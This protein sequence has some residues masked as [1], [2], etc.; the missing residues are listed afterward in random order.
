MVCP[1]LQ[2]ICVYIKSSPSAA[3]VTLLSPRPT[4]LRKFP[5]SFHREDPTTDFYLSYLL[6][7]Q[8]DVK[9]INFF[10][11]TNQAKLQREVNNGLAMAH[12]NATKRNLS[13]D[14]AE[15]QKYLDKMLELDH[16]H[17][18][19]LTYGSYQPINNIPFLTSS[20]SVVI[21]SV[22]VKVQ[23]LYQRGLD[24]KEG[25]VRFDTTLSSGQRLSQY[26]FFDLSCYKFS[27]KSEVRMKDL[28][29][30]LTAHGQHSLKA[31]LLLADRNCPVSYVCTAVWNTSHWTRDPEPDHLHKYPPGSNIKVDP[32]FMEKYKRIVSDIIGNHVPDYRQID[33]SSST[34]SVLPPPIPASSHSPAV[35]G[36]ATDELLVNRVGQVT[37]IVDCGNYGIAAIKMNSCDGSHRKERAIVLFDTCDV[38][39]GKVTVQQMDMNLNQVMIKGDYVK[40][41]AILV[42]QSENRK[43]IRYL[44]T[45]LVT[46]KLKRNVVTMKLP[47]MVPLENF[48]QIHPSKLNNFYTVVS[49]ICRSVPGDGEDECKGVSTDE[50]DDTP[51]L[52]DTS[53][54]PPIIG[55]T[56]SAKTFAKSGSATAAVSLDAYETER[57]K[58]K[59]AKANECVQQRR[60]LGYDKAARDKMLMELKVKNQ[61]MWRCSECNITCGKAGMEKHVTSKLHWDNVLINFKKIIDS[62]QPPVNC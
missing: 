61:L 52:I 23:L 36:W 62:E 49:A 22:P 47:D 10:G 34:K 46:G 11:A 3:P 9:A 37:S 16:C 1:V 40:V 14:R 18:R 54:P 57:E 6:P 56:L 55:A 28:A 26:A 60:K 29:S 31:H 44:A 30:V 27:L 42:P 2:A 51:P 58:K 21:P 19:T 5:E 53:K 39:M 15:Q 12:F 4:Q 7:V 45:S 59:L 25:L 33:S 38:W 20:L 24:I 13:G 48:D 35:L 32:L 8:L 50:D 17:V 41:K 43:N